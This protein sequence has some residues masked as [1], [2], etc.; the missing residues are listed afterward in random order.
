M[1]WPSADENMLIFYY[2]FLCIN[3]ILPGAVVVLSYS[4]IMR[5]VC[6]QRHT[7]FQQENMVAQNSQAN[8]AQGSQGQGQRSTG[9]CS[10]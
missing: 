10:Y 4:L 1:C 6:K 5:I 2:V 9:S 3:A 7:I 8:S